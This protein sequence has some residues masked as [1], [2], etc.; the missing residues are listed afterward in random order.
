MTVDPIAD[1]EAEIRMFLQQ[2]GIPPEQVVLTVPP[3]RSFGEASSNVAFR[4][5]GEWHAKPRDIAASLA[6]AF[7]AKHGRFI[8]R[9]EAAGAGFLNFYLN[10][11]AFTVHVLDAVAESGDL[12]GRPAG[13][14]PQ[15]L[16]VEHTSVNPNKE[17]HV[18][19]LRN[20][21]LGDL[22]VRIARQAGHD[23]EVQNYIDDTGRQAA[24]ALAALRLMTDQQ[25]EGEKYDHFSG[26][27]YVRANEHLGAV[28]EMERILSG[29]CGYDAAGEDLKQRAEFGK[30]LHHHVDV[31]LHELEGGELRPMVER[32]VSAQLETAGRLAVYYDLLVWESDIVRAHLLTDALDLLKSSSRVQIPQSGTYAGALIIEMPSR[33]KK[34]SGGSAARDD[35]GS[36]EPM[37]RVLV[38]SNGVPTY[39][40]KDIAYMLWKF[41]L[42]PAQLR[43]CDYCL[44]GNGTVLTTTCPDGAPFAPRTPDM[45]INVVAEHQA[46]PQQTVIEALRAIG[47]GDEADRFHHLSY[48]MVR[49]AGGKIS[50]RKGTGSA[51]DDVLDE[52]VAIA[53]ER[54]RAKWPDMGDEERDQIAESIGVGSIRYLMAQYSPV[55]AIE[56]N[57]EEVVSFE[58]D[59]GLYLQY[60]LV[61][62]MAVLRRA[63]EQLLLDDMIISQGNPGLLQEEAERQLAVKLGRFPTALADAL[64]T[65]N[66]NL[67]A[68]YAHTLAATFNQFYRDCPVLSAESDV[69]LARLRLVRTVCDVMRNVTNVLGVPV[70]ERL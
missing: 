38:R 62:A 15:R 22:V 54:V 44:Q 60:A 41:G 20:A 9:V 28:K 42:L 59:T 39:T 33:S 18:G 34:A 43:L 8:E 24:E 53:R 2:Q 7:N 50:G 21:V 10:Y 58:G 55:R 51:A 49:Q 19:H 46:L 65:L 63:H 68:E 61:R 47:F 35:D 32:I 37:L 40:G 27:L 17:W 31:L 69:R 66:V 29:D 11:D 70:V 4:L 1:F 12:Y 13:V 30:Q 3:E 26:R 57:I 36:T 45:V 64:R 14:R 23:V 56:F 67:V 5:A 6:A 48:G 25:N 52:A 16:L